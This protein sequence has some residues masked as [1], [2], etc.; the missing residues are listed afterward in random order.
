MINETNITVM[1]ASMIYSNNFY[2]FDFNKAG[3][4]IF[5]IYLHT[6]FVLRNVK[7]TYINPQALLKYFIFDT[8][9]YSE[10]QFTYPLYVHLFIY[11]Q[12]LSFTLN[13]ILSWSNAIWQTIY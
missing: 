11:V 1:Y 8:I 6:I 10:I 5:N 13:N 12:H 7:A 3:V 9:Y 2:A 4:V